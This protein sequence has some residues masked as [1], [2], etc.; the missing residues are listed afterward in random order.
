MI[1]KTAGHLGQQ[2]RRK[3]GDKNVTE[4]GQDPA[5]RYDTTKKVTQLRQNNRKGE[6]KNGMGHISC[7]PERLGITNS[8]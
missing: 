3:S 1:N 2:N 5:S 4:G 6:I 8:I 7:K